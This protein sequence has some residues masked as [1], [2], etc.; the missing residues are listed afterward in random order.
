MNLLWGNSLMHLSCPFQYVSYTV[1]SSPKLSLLSASMTPLPSCSSLSFLDWLMGF[2]SFVFSLTL[3]APQVLSLLPCSAHCP[4]SSWENSSIHIHLTA[5]LTLWPRAISS[6]FSA[7]LFVS[8]PL[9]LIL[10]NSVT[11]S[12]K[13]SFHPYV[14]LTVRSTM[15]AERTFCHHHHAT[16]YIILK[17]SVISFR[18]RPVVSVTLCLIQHSRGFFEICFSLNET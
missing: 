6:A 3:T 2:F 17:L 8:S 18:A 9:L 5:S 7:P 10:Q 12:G 13:V 14:G 11:S 15:S 1:P 4:E 16:L